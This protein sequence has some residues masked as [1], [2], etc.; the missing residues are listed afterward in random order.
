VE[1]RTKNIPGWLEKG[2]ILNQEFVY[3]TGNRRLA[4]TCMRL[5]NEMERFFTLVI[6]FHG[7]QPSLSE[8]EEQMNRAFL[9]RDSAELA[10]L[11][12]VLLDTMHG[13][14]LE[15]LQTMPS[16]LDTPLG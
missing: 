9:C 7:L 3:S 5:F 11:T 12:T 13:E 15:L 2:R 4:E 1:A 16:L 14:V 6:R 8:I 10:R